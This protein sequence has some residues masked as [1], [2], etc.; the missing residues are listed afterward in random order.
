MRLGV[1]LLDGWRKDLGR[2]LRVRPV[3]AAKSSRESIGRRVSGCVGARGTD[4]DKDRQS[5]W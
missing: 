2:G 4:N 1:N 5:R 3:A